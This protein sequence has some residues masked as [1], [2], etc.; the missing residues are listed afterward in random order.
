MMTFWYRVDSYV[1]TNVSE[2]YTV[3]IFMAKEENSTF[4]WNVGISDPH[5]ATTQNIFVIFK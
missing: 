2:K 4:L 3:S 5:G 1:D